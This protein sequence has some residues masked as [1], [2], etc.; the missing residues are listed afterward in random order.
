M[1]EITGDEEESKAEYWTN[2]A[3]TIILLLLSIF[4]GKT[5]YSKKIANKYTKWCLIELLVVLLLRTSCGV[6]FICLNR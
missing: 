5:L 6:Y 1:P 2:C 3:F 4:V